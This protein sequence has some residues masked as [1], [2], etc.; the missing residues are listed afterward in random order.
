MHVPRI[1]LLHLCRLFRPHSTAGR[2]LLR[3]M[4]ASERLAR[5]PT[6]PLTGHFAAVLARRPLREPAVIAQT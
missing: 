1:V 6:A 3:C 5:W 4:L 2:T